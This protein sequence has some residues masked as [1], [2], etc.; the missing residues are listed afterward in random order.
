[1]QLH[2]NPMPE[3]RLNFCRF[4]I[5]FFK[6]D[7]DGCV[8]EG[9]RNGRNLRWIPYFPVGRLFLMG[10]IVLLLCG[11]DIIWNRLKQYL[12]NTMHI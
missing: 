1:M 9:Q 2:D 6:K 5:I 10:F 11:I 3:K 7:A 8:R 4:G 12:K